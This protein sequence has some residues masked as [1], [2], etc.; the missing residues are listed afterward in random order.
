MQRQTT[1]VL[2]SLYL[3]NLLPCR[4]AQLLPRVIVA[5][6]RRSLCWWHTEQEGGD[7]QISQVKNTPSKFYGFRS[8]N[9]TKCRVVGHDLCMHW[10]NQ[11]PGQLASKMLTNSKQPESE[12]ADTCPWKGDLSSQA[13]RQTWKRDWNSTDTSIC[14][15]NTSICAVS[16]KKKNSMFWLY[17]LNIIGR[18]L[19]KNFCQRQNVAPPASVGACFSPSSSTGVRVIKP[20]TPKEHPRNTNLSMSFPF[21]EHRC[22]NDWTRDN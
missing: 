7:I 14:S 22:W 12:K 9:D 2:L 4:T 17:T 16:S 11:F 3:P 8:G 5:F 21:L 15:A 1:R 13:D 19:L 6:F 10:N 18:W 20:G